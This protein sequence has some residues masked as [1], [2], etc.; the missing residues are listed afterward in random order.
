RVRLSTGAH[1]W[2]TTST[3]NNNP[4][5]RTL[6][7]RRS[8]GVAPAVG[9]I[10][11]FTGDITTAPADL[12][13]C[14][15]TAGTPDMRDRFARADNVANTASGSA[16]HTHTSPN[17]THTFAPHTHPV[18][19]GVSNQKL[20]ILTD[21][22]PANASNATHT[23]T[24]ANTGAAAPPIGSS[25]SGTSNAQTLLPPY[26]TAHYVRIDSTSTSP[27]NEEVV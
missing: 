17:H 21:G 26:V 18:T 10:G 23:H 8:Q 16:T 19:I 13:R 2:G 27:L 9:L 20:G 7:L 24:S 25:T 1:T 4:P 14:D 6:R 3:F 22:T 12:H 5:T 15:G 11:L